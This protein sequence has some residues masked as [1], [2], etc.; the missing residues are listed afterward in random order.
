MGFNIDVKVI[1]YKWLVQLM[2]AW[3]DFC[4]GRAALIVDMFVNAF[5]VLD[6]SSKR[7]VLYIPSHR[8]KIN[9]FF[10]FIFIIKI[11]EKYRKISHKFIFIIL[12]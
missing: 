3:F 1:I 7:E 9:Q 6:I 11:F 5:D 4:A 2:C 10:I 12:I 8:E